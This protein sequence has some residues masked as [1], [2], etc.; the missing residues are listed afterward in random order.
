M[1]FA[2]IGV[3][4]VVAAA[5]SMPEQVDGLDAVL[6]ELSRTA[7]GRALVVLVAVGFTVFAGY[8]LIE[9]RYRQVAAGA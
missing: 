4:L 9:A 5:R 3:L 7:W 8:S 1:A 2:P 6:L